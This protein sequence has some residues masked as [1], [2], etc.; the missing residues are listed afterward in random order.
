MTD[1]SSG[2]LFQLNQ[3]ILQNEPM[4]LV[5][6]VFTTPI[7]QQH[8]TNHSDRISFTIRLWDRAGDKALKDLPFTV[9]STS[10]LRA[11]FRIFSLRESPHRHCL[12]YF[13]FIL[14]TR[15]VSEEES[16]NDIG[17]SDGD[18]IDAMPPGQEDLVGSRFV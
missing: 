13:K 1:I 7:F 15:P 9:K 8:Q 12:G 16:P 3:V 14:G 11:I 10:Q 2:F 18:C 4:L 5:R 6:Q 17:L